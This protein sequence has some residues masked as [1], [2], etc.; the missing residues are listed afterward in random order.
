[1]NKYKAIIGQVFRAAYI[2]ADKTELLIECANGK[3]Y[4]FVTHAECCSETWIEHVTLPRGGESEI[5][6]VEEVLLGE[7]MPTRQESDE[8]Y[9]IKIGPVAV[10]FRNSSNGYYGGSMCLHPA[11]DTLSSRFSQLNE[12]L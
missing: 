4:P 5:T 7:V 8:L 12:D 6:R 1:M 11:V 10:E 9:E 2:N 3:F